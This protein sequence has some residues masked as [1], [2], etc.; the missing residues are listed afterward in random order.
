LLKD[1]NN[2]MVLTMKRLL[3]LLSNLP[4]FMWFRPLQFH[5]VGVFDS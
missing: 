4:L 2:N 1:L 5:V 3:V